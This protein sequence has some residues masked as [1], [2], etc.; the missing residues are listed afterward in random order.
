M[1]ATIKEEILMKIT[2]IM[3]EIIM[4][5]EIIMGNSNQIM[6]PWRRSILVEEAQAVLMAVAKDLVLEIIGIIAEGF[7]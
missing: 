3:M 2:I 4:T 6:D 7:K 5:L 1:L